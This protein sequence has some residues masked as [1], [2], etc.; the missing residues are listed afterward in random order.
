MTLRSL[1]KLDV[2]RQRGALCEAGNRITRDELLRELRRFGRHIRRQYD[3][4]LSPEQEMV[5]YRALE[6]EDVL[7]VMPT[8]SGKSL[9]SVGEA[10]RQR[11]LF[12]AWAAGR[13]TAAFIRS[14]HAAAAFHAVSSARSGSNR[15]ESNS[16]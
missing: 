11:G 10:V 16:T 13:L 2:Y 5:V 4:F 14:R 6:G 12:V 3:D 8:G 9:T 7:A 1:S 15:V